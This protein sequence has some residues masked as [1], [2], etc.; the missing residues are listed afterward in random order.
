[1]QQAASLGVVVEVQGG[2]A[3]RSQALVDCGKG[4]DG[5]GKCHCLHRDLHRK[6]HSRSLAESLHTRHSAICAVRETPLRER[7][8][9]GGNRC[10]LD[11]EGLGSRGTGDCTVPTNRKRI[12]SFCNRR[13]MSFAPILP[14]HQ[15]EF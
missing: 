12:A 13:L 7:N 6:W 10:N 8:C 2:R 15:D 1:M 11:S 14:E 4:K 9:L 5:G 3:G